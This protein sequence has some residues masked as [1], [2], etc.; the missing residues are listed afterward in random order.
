MS[1]IEKLPAV[2]A[3][4]GRTLLLRNL[5]PFVGTAKLDILELTHERAV[6]VV[7]NRRPTRNHIGT[8]HAAV[9]A[10]LAETATGFVVAMNVPDDRVPVIKSI[11]VEYKKRAKGWLRAEATLT[12][13]Q[14]EEIRAT[15][16]GETQVAVR[17]TDEAGIE[18]VICTMIWAWTPKK[19][20]APPASA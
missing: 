14:I 16:K 20:A 1:R 18:P 6:V 19:R 13:A 17:V 2:L 11:G 4:R 7:H 9:T 5:V 3:R 12:P 10:L 8:L 15:E